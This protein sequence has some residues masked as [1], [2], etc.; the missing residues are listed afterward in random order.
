[1][2]KHLFI[3][4]PCQ[5]HVILAGVNFLLGKLLDYFLFPESTKER[6]KNAE[7]NYFLMFGLPQKIQKNLTMASVAG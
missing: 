4:S 6:K 2:V 7:E 5:N 1:M 3:S